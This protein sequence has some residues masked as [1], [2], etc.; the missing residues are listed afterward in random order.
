MPNIIA[1]L[2]VTDTDPPE[3]TIE[4]RADGRLLTPTTTIPP[5]AIIELAQAV[6]KATGNPDAE[7]ALRTLLQPVVD[8]LA[9]SVKQGKAQQAA[10]EKALADWQ[11]VA[12]APA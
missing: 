11:P 4:L 9:D 6:S 2:S 10:R 7:P 5:L 1:V 3:A 8:A 12:P